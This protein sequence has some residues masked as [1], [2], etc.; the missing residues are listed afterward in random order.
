MPKQPWKPYSLKNRLCFSFCSRPDFLTGAGQTGG[1]GPEAA[2]AQSRAEVRQPRRQRPSGLF[3]R[4][5]LHRRPAP[6][7]ALPRPPPPSPRGGEPRAPPPHRR[8]GV[9]WGGGQSRPACRHPLGLALRPPFAA[10]RPADRPRVPGA[11]PPPPAT[12]EG[13]GARSEPSP[14]G[15]PHVPP[16]FD[17]PVVN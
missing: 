12:L 5:A 13:T 2:R 11:A 6:R 15:A 9:G 4:L 3:L 1:S 17:V 10:G 7:F 16:A 14:A 8:G